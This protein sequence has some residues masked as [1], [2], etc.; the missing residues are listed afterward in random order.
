MRYG[1]DGAREGMV[2]TGVDP[3]TAMGHVARRGADRRL[4]AFNG[5]TNLIRRA[6]YCF[7]QSSGVDD[8]VV[9]A[10][11]R[12]ADAAQVSPGA[13]GLA[14]RGADHHASCVRPAITYFDFYA[15]IM[16]YSVILYGSPDIPGGSSSRRSSWD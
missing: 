11:L 6:A 3:H 12:A 5:V 14:V 1:D 10:G 9:A 15:L 2:R 8:A 7:P 4:C 13:G 16:V